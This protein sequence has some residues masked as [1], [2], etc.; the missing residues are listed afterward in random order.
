M[1]APNIKKPKSRLNK[2]DSLYSQNYDVEQT[3]EPV[4]PPDA[5]MYAKRQ[6][7]SFARDV[8]IAGL[9]PFNN[10]P[11]H[12][13]EGERLSDMIESIRAHGVLVPII[14]RRMESGLEILAGHNRVK[15]ARI[16]G[17]HT[18]PAIV[19]ENI[20][21]EDAWFYVVE[22]NLMQRSFSDMAHSEK[23]AVIAVQHSKLFSPGKRND[24]LNELAEL[25]KS[26]KI[27]ENGTSPQV[28]ERFR[29]DKQIGVMYSLSKNTVA[30]YLR[31]SKLIPPLKRRLDNGNI[32][33]LPAVTL[34][35][36]NPE[37][38]E[39]LD[40][41]LAA[42]NLSVSLKSSDLLRQYSE[43]GGLTKDNINLI[44]TGK[45]GHRTTTNRTPAIK[46]N[47]AVYA[48]YFKPEQSAK[49]VQEIV[50]KA[51][52]MYFKSDPR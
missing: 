37:E 50:R 3:G 11:F 39:I 22:T 5:E 4:T 10:H 40:E 34:S 25:E 13:Y 16:V 20:S 30:R 38:Q 21:D 51:L 28:G 2:L 42:A 49:E 45:A 12:E 7:L 36:L 33:F 52:D 19:L 47:K 26:H 43:K 35:F 8:D 6:L 29:S 15:A 24:I 9:L 27:N 17:L 18:V 1:S 31:V 46:I 48:K 14:T 32:P 44:L 23:A 41:C